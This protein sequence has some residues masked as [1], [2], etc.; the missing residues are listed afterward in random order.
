MPCSMRYGICYII[1]YI[2][3]TKIKFTCTSARSK[4]Y[5]EIRDSQIVHA[6]QTTHRRLCARFWCPGQ[7]RKY[8]KTFSE[9]QRRHSWQSL[10]LCCSAFHSNR[11]KKKRPADLSRQK[12]SASPQT[13]AVMFCSPATHSMRAMAKET[14]ICHNYLFFSSIRSLSERVLASF[15]AQINAVY[16]RHERR[17]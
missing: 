6:K 7:P 17:C 12:I 14:F 13:C 11:I 16:V 3:S 10:P 9:P 4:K 8:A 15:C 5:S 1:T 2:Q